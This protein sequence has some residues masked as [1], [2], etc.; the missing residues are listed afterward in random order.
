M[1]LFDFTGRLTNGRPPRSTEIHQTPDSVTSADT[2]SVHCVHPLHVFVCQ[3][4]TTPGQ[5]RG[6]ATELLHRWPLLLRDTLLNKTPPKSHRTCQI[7]S[8]MWTLK[9]KIFFLSKWKI[10]WNWHD[11]IQECFSSDEKKSP[12]KLVWFIDASLEII[13]MNIC[14]KLCDFR[15]NANFW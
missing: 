12:S 3:F 2:R 10:N 15:E 6:G 11:S 8:K 5:G 7:S 1:R 4:R 9:W 14:L 13:L